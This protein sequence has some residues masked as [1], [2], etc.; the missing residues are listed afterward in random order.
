M[1]FDDLLADELFVLILTQIKVKYLVF[2]ALLTQ[3]LQKLGSIYS[4]TSFT[5]RHQGRLL[6]APDAPSRTALPLTGSL[7]QGARRFGTAHTR[8]TN[9]RADILLRMKWLDLKPDCVL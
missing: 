9:C 2:P 8:V 4:P 1:F 3:N 5:V 7:R 6:D